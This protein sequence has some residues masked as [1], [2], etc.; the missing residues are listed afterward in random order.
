MRK[1]GDSGPAVVP[2]DA[3]K[4]LLLKALR[5]EGDLHMPPKRKLPDAVLA[6]FTR[7]IELGAPD[8][9]ESRSAAVVWPGP[10]VK[11]ATP[12]VRKGVAD[13]A[14]F[15]DAEL[16]RHLQSK[17]LR[18]VAL[19]DDAE[20]VRRAYLDLTGRIPTPEQ[21]RAYLDDSATDKRAKL[22]DQLL[23]SPHYG[24]HFGRV[25]RDWIAPAEL[26][27]EGNGGNQPIQQTR[28]LGKWFAGRFNANERWD[29]IVQ[30][31]LTVEGTLKDKPQA[32]FF[33]LVGDDGGR[34]QPAGSVRAIT[35][36]FLGQQFQCAECHDDPFKE[37]KQADFWGLAAYYRNTKYT[38]NGRY[39]GSISESF[40]E[41]N[42]G[43][44]PTKDADQSPNGNITIPSAALKNAGKVIPAKLLGGEPIKA[45]QKQALRPLLAE[46]VTSAENPYFARAFVNRMWAYFYSRGLVNPIDDMRPSVPASHP[47]LLDRLTDEF[48]ASGFDVKHLLR[49]MLL[50]Q[51]YARTSRGTKDDPALVQAFGKM[52][53]KLMSA[54]QLYESLQLAYGEPKL[55][56]RGYDAKAAA[57]FGES[58]PVLDAY[59]EFS[60]LF[61]TNKEDRTDFTHGIPQFLALLNHPRL[62]AGGKTTEALGKAGGKPETLVE[63]LYLAT[64]SRRPTGEETAEALELL[65]KIKDRKRG[66]NVLLWTLIN[67]SEFLLVR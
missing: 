12:P 2:G 67:R 37:W 49:C 55:D 61:V 47:A 19:A 13:T 63:T 65:G 21:T 28:D 1:G 7:W 62:R 17:S 60:R 53:I 35:S 10:R 4:S 8:P 14:A 54:D 45:Q 29:R 33:S 31:I 22:L 23:A 3:A 18:P 43:K 36:L 20:F 39:F 15:V 66:L 5:H 16:E 11:R 40:D 56:L 41:M 42:K 30:E 6:D 38:F 44:R 59:G 27:S 32:L 26:P 48:L 64:L 57:R 9:R 25:W 34:P 50:T 46:W 24:D 58:S 52:A 51:A